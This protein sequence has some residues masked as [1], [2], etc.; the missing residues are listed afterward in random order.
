MLQ[1]TPRLLALSLCLALAPACNGDDGTTVADSDAEASATSDTASTTG[2]TEASTTTEGDTSTTTGTTGASDTEDT[3]TTSTTSDGSTTVETTG[4]VESACDRLGGADGLEALHMDFL[5]RVLADDRING[6]FL[7]SDV[8]GPA[9][10][11]CLG[12]Q[13]SEALACPGADYACKSMQDAHFE[14]GISSLDFADFVEIYAAALDDHQLAHAAVTDDDK[15]ALLGAIAATE[16]DVVE[17]ADSNQ[18]VYQRIG[19]KPAL[20]A[21]VGDVDT[22]KTFVN[23][24]SGDPMINGFFT[25]AD[26]VRLATCFTRQLASIDGPV[27][28]GL[29]VDSPG[30]GIDDGVAL[31]APCV[32]MMSSHAGLKDSK[33]DSLITYFDFTQV[34]SD[35]IVAM[36]AATIAENDQLAI[37]GV[38]GPLCEDIVGD[39]P[40]DCPGNNTSITIDANGVNLAI[41]DDGY[42][43]TKASMVCA[44][45]A[46]DDDGINYVEEVE[47]EVGINHPWLGDLVIKVY[48]PANKVITVLS[49]AGMSELADD[50]GGV[51]VEGSDLSAGAPITFLEDAPYDAETLGDGV[52]LGNSG[53]ACQDDGRCEYTPNH[54]AAAAGS[55]ADLAGELA[56]GTW[57]I[58]AGDAGSADKGT[59]VNASIKLRK[60]K[61]KP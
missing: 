28:Y 4:G 6:Y 57:Q 1:R 14:L 50:G 24:V 48:S 60:V 43:G 13:V 39:H 22:V 10:I 20:K 42:T 37:I 3:T 30:P 2:T 38:L 51:S 8:D 7:N 46:V 49:R 47:V 34:L 56:P 55:L 27:K 12:D 35:L 59:L 31:D 18:T 23:A 61:Y 26:F 41:P 15:A 58:C 33:D 11:A 17:D 54:G 44:S 53:I 32:D 25:D 52:N 29:E 19:R 45:L 16:A 9:L 21:L 36:D 40:N 5:A